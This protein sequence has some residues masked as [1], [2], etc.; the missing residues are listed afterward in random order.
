MPLKNRAAPDGT[1]HAVAARGRFTGNRGVIHDPKTKQ[2]NGKRWTTKG[3][4]ICTCSWNDRRR[5]VWG[6]QNGPGRAGWSELFFLDEVT[7]LAAGHR[8]C[9]YCRRQRANEFRAAFATGNQIPMPKAP[10][11]DRLLH[12]ERRLSSRETARMIEPGEL[13]D[14]PDGTMI[15]AADTFFAVKHKRALAW[16]F[17]GYGPATSFDDMLRKSGPGNLFLITPKST[18]GALASGYCPAWHERTPY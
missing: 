11:M 17:S 13:P 12:A 9:F 3:W 14:L 6:Y 4:I 8:P 1:L 7:A 10:E 2:G 18:I 5:D 16:D 15:R